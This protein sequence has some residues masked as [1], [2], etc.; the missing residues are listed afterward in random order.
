VNRDGLLRQVAL[1]AIAF[2][3]TLVVLV[4]LRGL[5]ARTAGEPGRTPLP[6]PSAASPGATV[7]SATPGLTLPP[8]V[9]PDASN[10][11]TVTL[12]GAGD[13]ADCSLDGAQATAD[14]LAAN[15]GW[16]F[17]AGDN[18]Y[19]DGSAADYAACYGPTWGRFLDRTILPA[20]GNHDWQTR[21]AAGYLGYFGT[22]AA[23]NGT[24]W[25]S[26]DLGTWHVVVLD[27]DCASVGGCEA[28]SPQGR[29]LA[30]DLRSSP[31]RCTLAI[32]H[33]PRWSS[34]VHGNDAEVG[35]FWDLLHEDGAELV[36]NGHDHD[37]ERFAPMDPSG[38]E[39]RPGGLRELVVG[40][41]GADLR[42]FTH[43]AANTEFRQAGTWGVLRLTLHPL[44]YDWEFVPASGDIADS[45]SAPCH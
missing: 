18:A 45:G 26:M 16:I 13:I 35:P 1:V 41:G 38:K 6:A 25:Y 8:A 24:T 39:E 5:F 21:G 12:L 37:Y 20:A 9:G 10:A 28:G 7:G 43:A 2:A 32:W 44:N 42:S 15:E 3:A 40:T 31:A 22:R 27:S 4:G 11:P 19:E 30:T 23:P 29:W 17:T 14:L 36:I 34:G 33:H